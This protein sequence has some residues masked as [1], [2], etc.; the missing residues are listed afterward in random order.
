M[1]K[2]MKLFVMVGAFLLGAWI[3]VD[4]PANAGPAPPLTDVRILEIWSDGSPERVQVPGWYPYQLPDGITFMGTKLCVR[5]QFKG[6]PNWSLVFYS[7]FP[8]GQPLEHRTVSKDLRGNN[9][10]EQVI[11][12]D[13]KWLGSEYPDLYVKAHTQNYNHYGPQEQ[14]AMVTNIHLQWPPPF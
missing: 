8:S 12:I 11:E 14:E 3:F 4:A 7:T 13:Y 1:G 6:Y 5:T 10:W 9:T 2:L